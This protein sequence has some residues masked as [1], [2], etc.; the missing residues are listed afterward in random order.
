MQRS[1]V[2]LPEPD[3]PQITMRSPR[4]TVRL[5]SRNTLNSPNHLYR[6]RISTAASPPARLGA[7][8]SGLSSTAVMRA[9]LAPIADREPALDPGRV[10]RHR[11]AAHEVDQCRER[12][13]ARAGHRRRPRRIGTGG[14]DGP[15][16]IEDA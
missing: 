6:P 14:L 3:G 8:A 7:T 10:A 11:I 9:P 12:I 16:E 5:T 4:R 13:A 1:T 2:D 15:E